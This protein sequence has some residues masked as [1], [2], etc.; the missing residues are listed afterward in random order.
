MEDSAVLSVESSMIAKKSI[1]SANRMLLWIPILMVIV[2]VI[3]ELVGIKGLDEVITLLGFVGFPLIYV[4]LK[5]NGDFRQVFKLN[6]LDL[7]AL[8]PLALITLAMQPIS[9]LLLMISTAIFGNHMDFLFETILDQ[10]PLL[11]LVTL[12]VVPALGEEFLMRGIILHLYRPLKGQSQVIVNGVLFGIFHQNLNQFSYS[13]FI[14]MILALSVIITKSIWSGVLI[15]FLNNFLSYL[16]YQFDYTLIND[17]IDQPLNWLMVMVLSLLSA[18]IL[19]KLF[20]WLASYYGE[21]TIKDMLRAEDE[22]WETE[23]GC[24]KLSWTSMWTVS[25]WISLV[26]FVIISVAIIIGANMS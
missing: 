25:M 21:G 12:C 22:A 11:L 13:C 2:L 17:A 10:S 3:I 20:N 19:L 4:K 7:K 23:K 6:G 9:T 8:M 14:G 24:E 5:H 15:H 18:F 26:L 16:E 1:R